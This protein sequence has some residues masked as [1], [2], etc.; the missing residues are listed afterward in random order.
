MGKLAALSFGFCTDVIQI[1][2]SFGGTNSDC[3]TFIYT[4]NAEVEYTV[5]WGV[6]Y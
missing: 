2:H 4:C 6:K 1:I 5:K 3:L